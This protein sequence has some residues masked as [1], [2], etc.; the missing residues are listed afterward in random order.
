MTTLTLKF[1]PIIGILFFPKCDRPSLSQAESPLIYDVP[2]LDASFWEK[3][4]LV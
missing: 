1:N 2:K 4:E 3:A